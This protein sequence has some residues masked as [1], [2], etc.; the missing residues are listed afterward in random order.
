MQIETR[1]LSFDR[2]LNL[3]CLNKTIYE[4]V[5]KFKNGQLPLYQ[6]A[7]TFFKNLTD[8]EFEWLYTLSQNSDD[9]SVLNMVVLAEI[10]CSIEGNPIIL[11]EESAE[12]VHLLAA[13]M[14]LMSLERKNLIKLDYNRFSMYTG[15]DPEMITLL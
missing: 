1:A 12:Q 13:F 11:N 4:H 9:D 14:T 3:K 2:I 15:G 8:Q 10:L 6:T 7:G 5:L